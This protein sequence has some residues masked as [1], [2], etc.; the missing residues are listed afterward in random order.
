MSFALPLTPLPPLPN[1][2]QFRRL[3]D[4][5]HKAIVAGD[6]AVRIC[7]ERWAENYAEEIVQEWRT[8]QQSGESLHTGAQAAAQ[9]LVA[10]CYGFA[11]WA[12][13]LA[14]LEALAITDSQVSAFES[15]TD[16][17][18]DGDL[19][20]LRQLLRDRP[21]LIVQ[22]STRAHRATL[23]H[24]VSANGVEDFRQKTPANIEEIAKVLLD[25]G[26]DVNAEADAYGGRWATLGLAATS[27]HPEAAGVQPALLDLLLRR[28]AI[29]D[30]SG[31]SS[32]VNACLHN[33]RGEAAEFL[34]CRGALL[35]LEGAAGV[36][37]LD[38][39]TSFVDEYTGE[40]RGGATPQ[41]MHDGFGWA[42]GFGRNQVVE[43]LLDH[44]VGLNTRL[45]GGET[46][47]HWAA[48]EGLADTVA[49]LLDQKAA[50]DV[51][52]STHGG[53]PLDWAVYGWASRLAGQRERRTYHETVAR[54]VRA[55]SPVREEWLAD[56]VDRV[57]A[58]GKVLS[59]PR[60]AMALRG[61]LPAVSLRPTTANRRAP[62][63]S[64]LVR[65]VRLQ[66][67]TPRD[68]T[69]AFSPDCRV[70]A[71]GVVG[72]TVRLWDLQ[73]GECLNQLAGHRERVWGLAWSRDAR[74]ILSGAWDKTARLWDARSG[75]CLQ[76]LEGHSGFVRALGF[77]EDGRHA[78]TAGGDRHDRSVRVWDLETGKCLM[79]LT[80]HTDGAYCA[81]LTAD[82]RRAVSGSRD[83]T[84]R[85]WD[86]ETGACVRTIAAH[87]HHVQHLAWSTNQT[88]V[89]S[90]SMHVRL[91]DLA[92]GHCVREFAGHTDTVRTVEWSP[93]GRLMVFASHDRTVRV[94]EVD[95]GRC[96]K[97]L[98]QHE[99]LVVAASWSPD[100][101]S[102]VSC[103]EGAEIRIWDWANNSTR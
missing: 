103:D 18:V 64:N 63:K 31:T 69:C 88:Q 66:M 3:A 96:V 68:L 100:Q 12:E 41:Q 82:G 38:I 20:R 73:T 58:A 6:A 33:G 92:T 94:W 13:F 25:S 72:R 23:L 47:L 28:G 85:V 9:L 87:A 99:E 4:D 93:D 75:E 26:A 53:T 52:D 78:I 7:A 102:I 89:L 10:R 39:V 59:D 84:V 61:D 42:C 97:T 98:D 19:N 35:D 70:A 32:I 80:G 81:L 71:T 86:P 45:A 29:L 36:G 5:L 90:C 60:M 16:A 55:G 50:V 67:T 74:H 49:L 76:V 30:A 48:W 62:E 101:R 21:D 27:C 77:S 40:L 51:T 2:E 95:S 43:Y 79:I 56:G 14:H 57:H 34:A 24:Y 37:R 17:I 46:G 1:V 65:I 54:L 15:A 8:M 44:G 22:R 11:G 83:G 91:W